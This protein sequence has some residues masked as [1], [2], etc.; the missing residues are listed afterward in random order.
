MCALDG[1]VRCT[2][3]APAHSTLSRV[4]TLL[5]PPTPPPPLAPPT[6]LTSLHPLYVSSP[7]ALH[8]RPAQPQLLRPPGLG[9]AAPLGQDPAA[10]RRRAP[11]P[12]APLRAGRRAERL[13]R[14]APAAAAPCIPPLL[15]PLIHE[16]S[17]CSVSLPRGSASVAES[18][19]STLQRTSSR[20]RVDQSSMDG[21]GIDEPRVFV[22]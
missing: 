10:A 18:E 14:H 16:C 3:L 17:P 5:A 11:L 13:L 4:A 6:L 19:L 20:A 1:T 2:H 7:G 22:R 9:H 15:L 12:R 8:A 21:K